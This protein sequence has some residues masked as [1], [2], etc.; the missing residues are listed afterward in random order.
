MMYSSQ[1]TSTG[2]GVPRAGACRRLLDVSCGEVVGRTKDEIPERFTDQLGEPTVGASRD[3]WVAWSVFRLKVVGTRKMTGASQVQFD[4]GAASSCSSA[5]GVLGADWRG[6]GWE[7]GL[8]VIS[9]RLMRP[10]GNGLPVWGR[11]GGHVR[12]CR[13]S[14]AGGSFTRSRLGLRGGDGVHGGEGPG[15]KSPLGDPYGAGCRERSV[16]DGQE[17]YG[18]GRLA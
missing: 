11:Y 9:G 17:L 8:G 2:V 10:A 13:A 5:E 16:A 14:M 7:G 6:V 18:V 15:R 1:R 3:G 12:W 4:S